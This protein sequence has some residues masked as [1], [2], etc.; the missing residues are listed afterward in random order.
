MTV[1]YFKTVRKLFKIPS[2]GLPWW[3]SGSVL[4]LQGAWVQSLVGE[5]PARHSQ[6][7]NNN[8][9]KTILKN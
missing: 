8:N 5:D 4:P 1:I 6:N 9:N 3:Y 2:T 7:K